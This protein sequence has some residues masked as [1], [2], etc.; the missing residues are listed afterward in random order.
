[1]IRRLRVEEFK[2]VPGSIATTA[3]VRVSG[4]GEKEGEENG[5]NA[6]G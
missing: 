1:M 5:E 6:R 3:T 2:N 4:L